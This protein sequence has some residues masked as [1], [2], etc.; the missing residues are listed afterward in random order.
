MTTSKKYLDNY[1]ISLSL[2][3]DN[4]DYLKN[5]NFNKGYF[6]LNLDYSQNGGTHWISLIN[7]FIFDYITLII[8]FDPFGLRPNSDFI[9]ECSNRNI[10]LAYNNVRLQNINEENCGIWCMTFLNEFF[11]FFGTNNSGDPIYDD[12]LYLDY[13]EEV[14]EN[15]KQFKI[16]FSE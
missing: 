12:K 3:L 5:Y 7:C 11:D 15:L 9:K 8:Y 6:I 13:L 10:L 4:I 1:A 14:L 2:K 16:N